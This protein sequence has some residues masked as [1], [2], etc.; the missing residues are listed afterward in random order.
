[1]RNGSKA[2]KKLEQLESVGHELNNAEAAVF[3]A[4]SAR[5]NYLAQDR[6]DIVFSSKEL[7]REFAAPN[8]KS[9]Q[10]LKRL[11]RYFFELITCK[12]NS[13]RAN[14][15]VKMRIIFKRALHCKVYNVNLTC[16]FPKLCQTDYVFLSESQLYFL[17]TKLFPIFK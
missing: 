15:F 6:A 1:M 7:C 5:C 9:Y 11:A 10:K 16:S 13:F 8:K 12:C 2:T 14:A 3:T 17:S 4:L